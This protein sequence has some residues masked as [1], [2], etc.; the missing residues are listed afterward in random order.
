VTRR[1]ALSQLA[2]AIA[3]LLVLAA[4]VAKIS[5]P[6]P[7][8]V[9]SV[10]AARE[11]SRITLCLFF[12]LVAVSISASFLGKDTSDVRDR[13]R[14]RIA[15]AKRRKRLVA[16]DRKKLSLQ[17]EPLQTDLEDVQVSLMAAT[18]NGEA[19]ERFHDDRDTLIVFP[20]KEGGPS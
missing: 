8:V 10:A 9:G 17:M 12:A 16:R 15:T 13:L 19:I 7:E 3:M 18:D 1:A 11:A 6:S 20:K 2:I 4:V 5:T 14:M